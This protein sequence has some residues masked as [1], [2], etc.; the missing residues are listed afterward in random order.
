MADFLLLPRQNKGGGGGGM[1]KNRSYVFRAMW[2]QAGRA[3]F[4]F[5]ILSSTHTIIIIII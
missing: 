3:F 2:F 1:G 4:I 5:S